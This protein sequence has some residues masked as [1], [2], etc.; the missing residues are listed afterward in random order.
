MNKAESQRVADYLELL[1]YQATL[2]LQKADLV[3]LNT[4]VVRQSAEDK[5]IGTLGYLKGI[6][7]SKP[8]LSILVTGCF[9]D[10]DVKQ[11]QKSF[12]HVDLFF[13]PGD[14]IGLL[15][16]TEKQGISIPG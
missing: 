4:C 2:V 7:N 11:L 9:V 6:K 1:G 3:L 5:V 16:W 13:K 12:P 15:N 8:D 14:Y 10:S